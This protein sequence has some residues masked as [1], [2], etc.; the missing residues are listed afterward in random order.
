MGRRGPYVRSGL[1]DCGNFQ[2]WQAM[3]KHLPFI[4]EGDVSEEEAIE[5]QPSY[6]RAVRMLPEYLRII[7]L[8]MVD[9][10]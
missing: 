7:V 9:Y 5:V 10:H 6:A 1:F 3:S 2:G 8:L 4:F